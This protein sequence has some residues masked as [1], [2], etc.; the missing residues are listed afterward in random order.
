MRIVTI[1][2]SMGLALLAGSSYAGSGSLSLSPAASSKFSPSAAP[3][4]SL[5]GAVGLTGTPGPSGKRERQRA[6]HPHR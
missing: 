2:I 3:Q 1:A 6:S 5:R 4:T